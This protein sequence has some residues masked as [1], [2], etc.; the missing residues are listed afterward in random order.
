MISYPNKGLRFINVN[1]LSGILGLIFLFFN[2]FIPNCVSGQASAGARTFSLGQ[3][4][5]ALYDDPWALFQNPALMKTNRSAVSFYAMRYAGL[6]ELTDFSTA[7]TIP[8]SA[9]TFGF[10]AHYYGFDLF[11][12]TTFHLA[13]MKSFGSF[14][15]GLIGSGYHIHIAKGYGSAWATGLS[16]GF[17]FTPSDKVRI[18]TRVRNINQ[19]SYSDSKEMLFRELATGISYKITSDLNFFSEL[20]KDVRFPVSLRSGLEFRIIQNF[21]LRSGFTTEP[22][23]WSFGFGFQSGFLQVNIAVQ[24]HEV[25]G[26]SPAMDTGLYF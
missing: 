6:Q 3:A 8:V 12:E 2:F 7:I 17:A 16:G 4:G 10:G 26:L 21:F 11:R 15:F 14:S 9:G 22:N 23:T 20:S 1:N 5:V 25:L 18:G 19:P 24:R 13:Y